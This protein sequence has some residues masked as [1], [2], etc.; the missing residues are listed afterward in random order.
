MK[1]PPIGVALFW[2][3]LALPALALLYLKL[4]LHR[5]GDL[6]FS[7]TGEISVWLTFVALAVTPLERRF[8][9]IPWLRKLRKARRHIG[10]AAFAY[11]L[12]HLASWLVAVNLRR[13]LQSF[14]DPVL[15]T[16]WLAFFIML[17]MAW[18]SNDA[19]MR[20]MGPKWK[21]LQRW[22]YVTPP[23]AVLHW[24]IAVDYRLQTTLIYG[25]LLLVWAVLRVMASRPRRRAAS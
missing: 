22:V 23:L 2:I 15:I 6:F 16:G 3:A 1:R 13:I 12:L 18:T 17:A 8:P 9:G 20:R 24:I 21:Q 10:V 11:A 7:M 14:T 25:G 5:P 4:V 19:S